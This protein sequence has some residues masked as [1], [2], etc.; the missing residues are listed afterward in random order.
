MDT[1]RKVKALLDALDEILPHVKPWNELLHIHAE[2]LPADVQPS[3]E[4][5]GTFEKSYATHEARA[6]TRDM[7]TLLEARQKLEH[8]YPVQQAR[9]SR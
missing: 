5:E 3:A 6:F 7:L 8:D 2:G 4:A 1:D 9:S